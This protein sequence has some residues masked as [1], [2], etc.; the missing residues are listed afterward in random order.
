MKN[1]KF[2]SD[3]IIN[4]AGM[5]Q[6]MP[7]KE[8]QYRDEEL[9]LMYQYMNRLVTLAETYRETGDE[10]LKDQYPLDDVMTYHIGKS[11]YSAKKIQPWDNWE[12]YGLNPW[13]ADIL[14]RLL[15][16]KTEPGKDPAEARIEDYEKMKHLCDKRI[17]QIRKGDTWYTNIVIPPWA[18]NTDEGK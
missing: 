14:K 7:N 15:R 13:D 18:T 6:W 12:E 3:A 4:I 10:K 16:T 5:Q 8:T 17:N 1:N 2:I 11:N 9:R